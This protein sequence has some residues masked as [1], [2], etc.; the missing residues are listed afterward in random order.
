[1]AGLLAARALAD[2]AESVVVLER[3]RLPDSRRATRARAAGPAPAPAPVGGPRPAARVVPRHRGRARGPRRRPGRRHRRVGAPGRRLPRPRRLGPPAISQTRPLLE[4]VVRARV[5]ALPGVTVEDGVTVEAGHAVRASRHR[6]RRR[7]PGTDRRTSSSTA[8][9]AARASRTTSRRRTCSTRPSPRSAS[10]SATRP[11][12]CAGRRTTSRATSSCASRTRARSAAGAV[13][14]VEGDRWQVTLAGV[15]GDVPPAHRRGDRGVRGEPADAR[16]WRQLIDRCERLSDV[17]TYRFPS[18]QRRHYEKVRDL[19]PGL[20]MLGDASSSFDPIY[21]QGMTSSALQAAALGDVAARAGVAAAELP[22]R[23]HRKAARII[24][25]PW[26]IAVGGDFGHPATDGPRPLGTAQ[27][28]GYIQRGH[29]AASHASVPVARSF[30]RV[31]Q[32]EDPPTALARTRRMVRPGAARGA[33]VAGRDGRPGAPPAGGS[34]AGRLTQG[35]TCGRQRDR[36]GGRSS[37]AL[38]FD[39]V[40]A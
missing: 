7:R 9:G 33:A 13:L 12:R 2:H 35:L 4:H 18:S 17:A 6:G 15:H 8:P 21:G 25:A 22:K 11:S 39:R 37:S 27:L 5:A 31:L 38:V 16:R 40:G 36:P 20:V 3:E 1:M 19:L 26:R 30:N 32:L 34:A 14:P 28:N 29:P 23:F 10:T 24:E